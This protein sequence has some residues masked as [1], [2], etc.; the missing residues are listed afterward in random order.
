ME[1]A[2]FLE[3]RLTVGKVTKEALGLDESRYYLSGESPT[4]SRVQ[5]SLPLRETLQVGLN[6]SRCD[7]DTRKQVS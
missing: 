2:A 3:Y 6:C 5:S 7:S 4:V 1:F